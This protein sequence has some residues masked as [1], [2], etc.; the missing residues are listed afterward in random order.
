MSHIVDIGLMSILRMLQ[1][2]GFSYYFLGNDYFTF[3]NVNEKEKQIMIID[4][5]DFDNYEKT[6]NI[7]LKN[8]DSISSPTTNPS[9]STGSAIDLIMRVKE[10]LLNEQRHIPFY[11]SEKEDSINQQYKEYVKRRVEQI[12]AIC[13]EINNR[14]YN[15]D[16]FVGSTPLFREL[17]NYT[18]EESVFELFQSFRYGNSNFVLFGKNG[19]GKTTLLNVLHSEMFTTNSI[20]VP[21]TRNINYSNDLFHRT[22]D[23]GLI[24]AISCKEENKAMFYLSLMII[25]EEIVQRREKKPEELIITNRVIQTFNSLG[26]DREL[27]IDE[28][29]DLYLFAKEGEKYSLSLASDGEKSALYFIMIAFLSPNNSFLI[30]DEPENHLNGALMKKL[31]DILENERKDIKYIYSTHN[32]NFIE[33]RNNAE[34]IYLKKT[35][36]NNKWHFNKFNEY[37]N[38][39][40]DLILNVE[41]TNDNVIFCE[42]EDNNSFDAKLYRILFPHYHILPSGGCE[43]VIIRTNVFNEN[44]TQLRKQAFGLIDYDFKEDSYIEQLKRKNVFVLKVNEIENVFLLEDCLGRVSQHLKVSDSIENIKN[45]LIE[46]IKKKDIDIKKDY[47]TKLLKNIHLKNKIDKIDDLTKTLD[48]INNQNKTIFLSAFSQFSTTLNNAITSLD[49]NAL[50]KLVPGKLIINN[51]AKLMGLND[52]DIYVKLVLKL[53]EE[54]E[55]LSITLKDKICDLI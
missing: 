9:S 38:L 36:F 10:R 8:F 21:A 53:L 52:K 48:S 1:T 43:K 31:F 19:S 42:G 34:I 39:P 44:K 12:F 40:L 45:N 5:F 30:I 49:Y 41:G 17:I 32:I 37:T 51:C 46:I 20:V 11:K 33:S 27:F 6:I 3:K 50:M 54:D 55:T 23:V 35:N 15:K 25:K 2:L 24:K 29:G 7:T 47:A 28:N 26:M 13:K 14:H 16:K 18:G 22:S 4:N